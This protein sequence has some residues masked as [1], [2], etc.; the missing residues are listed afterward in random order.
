MSATLGQLDPALPQPVA[1]GAARSAAKFESTYTR[2]RQLKQRSGAGKLTGDTCDALQ[3]TDGGI[4]GG[5]RDPLAGSRDVFALREGLSEALRRELAW[6]S[7]VL[8]RNT[9]ARAMMVVR[10]DGTVSCAR[11]C[12]QVPASVAKD[13]VAA[14]LTESMQEACVASPQLKQAC[15]GGSAFYLE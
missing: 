2:G 5:S 14:N 13:Q 9:N 15:S 3:A 11:G 10:G 12:L 1:Q 4:N 7:F 8:L 6:A